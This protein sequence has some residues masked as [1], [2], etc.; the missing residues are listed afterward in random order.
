MKA[1]IKPKL[2][3]KTPILKLNTEQLLLENNIFYNNRLYFRQLMITFAPQWF[4]SLYYT[5]DIN[6]GIQIGA[7]WPQMGNIWDFFRSESD[8][9]RRLEVKS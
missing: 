5:R 6:F 7:D 3:P 4:A 1:S 9:N 2:R 8:H